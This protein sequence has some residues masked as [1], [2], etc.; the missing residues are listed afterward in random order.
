MSV[1]R[2][3]ADATSRR[4]PVPPVFDGHLLRI[5]AGG[6]R[7]AGGRL[8]TRR[9]EERYR[10]FLDA[11][12]VALY[13]T[14][15]SGRITFYNQAAARFWGRRPALGELFCGSARLFSRDGRP[16]RHDECPMAIALLEG[17]ELHG[18]EAVAER[19]DGGRVAFAAYPSLLRDDLGRVVGAVNVL[20]DVTERRRIEDELRLTAVELQ[21]SNAVKD[22]FLGLVS[23]ELRTPV[24]TILGN[25]R[26]LHDRDGFDP[27]TRKDMLADIASDAERLHDLVENLL[28][29]TRL[30]AGQQA[31]LEPTVLDRVVESTARSFRRR[32]PGREIEVRCRPAGMIVE[33]DRTYL[34]LVLENLVTNA[35]KYSGGLSPIEIDATRVGGE[36]EVRVLDRGMSFTDEDAGSLFEPFFRGERARKA[37]GGVGI[38][39]AVC[40]RIVDALGGRI[41]AARRDGGGSEFGFALP[42]FDEGERDG[43]ARTAAPADPT[44]VE[45]D[46]IPSL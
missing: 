9:T 10:Q 31:D 33:A 27:D 21:A 4:Q 32:Y 22:E 35:A 1:D 24:T 16:M 6:A 37:S 11:L 23:H 2:R 36:A 46:R 42:L 18:A 30:G 43:R 38:G 28:Y 29:L 15:A 13:T 12:G 39:L 34:E 5:I 20:V 8:Q 25:A 26:L 14:D 17:R 40:K 19:P 7:R 44:T 3:A 45:E 41:W